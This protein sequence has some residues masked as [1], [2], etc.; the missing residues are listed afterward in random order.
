MTFIDSITNNIAPAKPE[1]TVDSFD[2][3]T[4]MGE[5]NSLEG[6]QTEDEIINNPTLMRGIREI[7]KS[8]YSEDTRNKFSFDEKY[9]KDL[10]DEETFEEWQNWMRSLAG[11]QTVTSANDAAWFARADGDQ[12][13]LMGAS[14]NIMEKMPNLFSGEADFVD[15][16]R[17]YI[18]AAVY[19]PTTILGLG[20]GRLWSAGAT[21]AAGMGL[22]VAAKEAL[23][24]SLKKGMTNEQAKQVQRKVLENGF[25]NIKV[26]KAIRSPVVGATATDI[27]ASVGTDY[28]YQNI[29]IG[30][31]VQDEFSLPQSVGV[32][33]S[34]IALPSLFVT[35][36]VIKDRVGKIFNFEKYTDISKKFG[37]KSEQEI[38]DAVMQLSLIHI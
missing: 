29:R 9:D 17:D 4:I 6:D 22:R 27:V 33:L 26:K 13:A 25:K 5:L 23:K 19:D 7:M 32:A 30:S 12:R 11:G 21:K 31:G 14:F 35:G 20:I 37:G 2:A 15:G 1:I 10:S 16:A 34:V 18:K 3:S 28:I 8:R 38:T 36:K 24:Q